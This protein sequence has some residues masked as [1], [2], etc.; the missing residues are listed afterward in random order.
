[1]PGRR[2]KDG[3]GDGIDDKDRIVC[4]V[5]ESVVKAGC[6]VHDTPPLECSLMLPL[7][8]S[9]RLSFFMEKQVSLQQFQQIRDHVFFN[10]VLT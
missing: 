7:L 2:V 5:V 3:P 9:L 8:S 1:M 6:M 4:G 10:H